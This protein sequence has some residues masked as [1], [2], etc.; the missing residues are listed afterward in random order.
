MNLFLLINFLHKNIIKNLLRN[1]RPKEGFLWLCEFYKRTVCRNLVL[2]FL[3]LYSLLD[4]VLQ[5][6]GK[7]RIVLNHCLGSLASLRQFRAIV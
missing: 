1:V 3:V 2:I 6:L 5:F 7:F 4:L